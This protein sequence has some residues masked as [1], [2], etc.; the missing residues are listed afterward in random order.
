[1]TYADANNILDRRREGENMLE[2]VIDRAL[3]LTG[4]LQLDPVRE[5]VAELEIY[6]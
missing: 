5:A 6:E 2:A 4:D 1:M 3:E